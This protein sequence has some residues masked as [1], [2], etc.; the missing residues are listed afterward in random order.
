MTLVAGCS[1]RIVQVTLHAPTVAPWSVQA[2][3]MYSMQVRLLDGE[4]QV[5][6]NVTQSCGFRSTRWDADHGFFLN[7][8]HTQFRGFS[9][10]NSFAGFGVAIPDRINLFRVQASKALGGSM[11]RMSHNPY[12]PALYELLSSAGVLSWDENRDYGLEYVQEMHD[13]VKRDRN[14]PSVVVWSFCNE[15]ECGQI[16]NLTGLAF[17]A[18]AKALDPQRPTADNSNGAGTGGLDVQGFSHAGSDQ[19]ETF[20]QQNPGIPTVLSECCSCSTQR[21]MREEASACMEQQNSPGLLPFV[22]G[23]LGVWTLMDYYGEPGS[24]PSVSSSY[25]NFD[26][27]GFPKPHAYWYAVNWLGLVSVTDYARPALPP[28]PVTR[29]LDLPELVQGQVAGITSAAAAEVFVNGRS[30]GRQISPQAAGQTGAL[31]WTVGAGNCSFPINLSGVQ[32]HDL[33][34]A[35]TAGNPEQCQ[36][37]CCQQ[38]VCRIWVG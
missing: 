21:Y 23:S 27:A 25:G 30:L 1:P 19:F 16:T 4:Q 35:K 29:I 31:L 32:C 17:R 3:H 6:D 15:Y 5:R 14:S 12:T 20:H 24:W 28:Y 22:T 37:A 9:H 33:H 8:K 10:H 26:L 36:D 2:P 11:W 18:A 34:A 13:M 7:G 38:E